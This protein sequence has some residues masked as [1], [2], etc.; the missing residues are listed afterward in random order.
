MEDDA[1]EGFCFGELTF[2]PEE[3]DK[4]GKALVSGNQ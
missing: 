3:A 2:D 4:D 1:N